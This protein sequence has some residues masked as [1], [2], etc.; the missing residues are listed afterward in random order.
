M[1]KRI[2]TICYALL[3]ATLLLAKP[4]TTSASKGSLKSCL[5]QG[6]GFAVAHTGN[7][8]NVDRIFYFFLVYLL[9][10]STFVTS[11]HFLCHA[12][13]SVPQPNS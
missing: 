3:S 7:M 11:M 5:R 9:F 2:L 6:D 1:M 8:A 10:L 12:P 13:F 4:Y